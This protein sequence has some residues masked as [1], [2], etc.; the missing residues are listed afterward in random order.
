MITSSTTTVLGDGVGVGSGAIVG[1]GVGVG[2]G[3]GVASGVA[4]GAGVAVGLAVGVGVI[5]GLGEGVIVGLAV[6]VGVGLGVAVVGMDAADPPP[7]PTSLTTIGQELEE[8]WVYLGAPAKKYK[9]DVFFEDGLEEIIAEQEQDIEE[10]RK[11]YEE[12]YTRR[13]DKKVGVN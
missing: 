9:R 6:G 10:L 7:P 13:K 4:V 5:V 3:V 8:G 11:K 2:I 1:S 12:L